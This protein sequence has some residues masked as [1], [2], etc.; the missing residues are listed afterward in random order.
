[1]ADLSKLAELLGYGKDFAQGASN[2]IAGNVSAPVDGLAWLLRKS[3]IPMPSNPV[4]GSDWMAQKGLTQEPQNRIAGLLGETAGMAG[5]MVAAAKAPQIANGL[6]GMYENAVVPQT[7]NKQAGMA[8]FDTSG[9]PDRGR[10]LIQSSAESLAEKLR[11]LNFRADVQHSGSAAGLSSYLK[12][13]DPSTG[14]YFDDVRLSGHSKGVF[15]SGG[16]QNVATQEELSGVIARA[17]EMRQLGPASG[18]QATAPAGLLDSVASNVRPQA[19]DAF[20]S[21]R[22]TGAEFTKY[23]AK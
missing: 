3:G 19:F 5:P 9:L 6:L 10:Q 1:M 12:V 23:R 4:G 21:A 14:R 2:A 7:L 18:F 22:D 16:V 20:K 11:G 13:F 8:L 17:L 15:N